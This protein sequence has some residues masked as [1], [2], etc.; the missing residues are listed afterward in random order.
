LL[1][2]VSGNDRNLLPVTVSMHNTR[3]CPAVHRA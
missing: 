3:V 1:R 2:T